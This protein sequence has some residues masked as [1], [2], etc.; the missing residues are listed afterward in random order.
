MLS[1]SE[2]E[3]AKL[4]AIES[5]AAS[6]SEAIESRLGSSEQRIADCNQ[7]Q[8]LLVQIKHMQGSIST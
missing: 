4:E 7:L 3:T 6:L 5:L 2:I 8:K 1:F